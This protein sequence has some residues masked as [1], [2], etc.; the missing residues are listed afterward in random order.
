MSIVY[1]Q[2]DIMES[3]SKIVVHQVNCKG[4]M[5][6]GLALQIKKRWPIVFEMYR[7]MCSTWDSD[8]PLLGQCLIVPTFQKTGPE[9]VANLFGQDGYGRNKQYTDY[10]ALKL[11]FY[12]LHNGIK[13]LGLSEIAFP[14]KIGCGLGGGDWDVVLQMIKD[15]FDDVQIIICRKDIKA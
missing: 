6:S 10:D 1:K 11:A 2:C 12:N 9:Y 4:V 8:K 5:G 3:D 7:N 13:R 14:Y 15:E